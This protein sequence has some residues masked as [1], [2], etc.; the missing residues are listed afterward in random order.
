VRKRTSAQRGEDVIIVE[1]ATNR[2]DILNSARNLF[3]PRGAARV[4]RARQA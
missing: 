3:A 1:A 4:A 2:A